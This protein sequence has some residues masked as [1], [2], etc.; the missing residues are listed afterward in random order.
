MIK[1]EEITGQMLERGFIS[2]AKNLQANK[3]YVNS[4]NV[5]PVPDGDTGTNMYLT[6][7]SAVASVESNKTV[8]E[9][10]AQ[11]SRGAL[12]GARGNSGVILSQIIKGL[13]T[14]LEGLETAGIEDMVDAFIESTNA[15]YKAVMKPTEG[16]I[17]TVVRS[18]SEFAQENRFSYDDMISFLTDCS[19]HAN[20]VLA[21]TPDMLRELK[22]AGVVDAGGKGYL[23]ILD[24]L[25]QGLVSENVEFEVSID[26][27]EYFA[28]NQNH[29]PDEIK[30]SYCTEFMINGIVEDPEGF[31]DEISENG[32]CV[33]VVNDRDITKVH[34]HT[35]NPG[36]VLERAL[37]MGY[38]S[39]IKIDNMKIQTANRSKA[40]EK[41]EREKYAFIVVSAGEGINNMFSSLGVSKIIT[42][43]QTMNPST[44][45]ILAAIEETNADDIYIF[46][47]NKNIIL[48]ANQA[49]D[50]TDKEVR[51]IETRQIP[52]A[53]TA[54]LA[55]DP[56]EDID[57]NTRNMEEAIEDVRTIQ[58]TRAVR[59]S[60]NNGLKIKAGDFIGLI[61]GGIETSGP[62]LEKLVKSMLEAHVTDDDYLLTLY[63]GKDQDEESYES[64]HEKLE[65]I[66][67]DIDVELVYG[68]QPV[69][70]YI[71]SI[72]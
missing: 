61:N 16:T 57:I 38:L 62:D 66:Y 46:P 55:F 64:L 72:E 26:N 71:I 22:D 14:G 68:A 53:F 60:I 18:V 5:Y 56:D 32:D 11:I 52:E 21:K 69:Y 27:F 19:V 37:E 41:K 20:G 58:V 24:G 1:I 35:N 15:A 34:I 45:E 33:I 9:V 49:K 48:S 50:L 12:M 23:V 8:S 51:V 17:L 44:E 39:D 30:F 65:D 3:E 67:D 6:L 43:G 28:E 7:N 47:N 36:K 63:A 31:R 40:P 4:L 59:D 13:S 42:G 29:N 10:M 25:I 70:D 2:A 54:F